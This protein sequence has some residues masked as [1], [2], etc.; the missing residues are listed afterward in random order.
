[1]KILTHPTCQDH[2]VPEGHPERPQRL[3]SLLDHLERTGFAQDHAI[4]HAPKA[5]TEDILRAHPSHYLSELEKLSP[6]EGINPVDPDT[7][8]SPDSYAAACIAA[9]AT[10]AGVDLL[11]SDQEKRVFCAV[12]PPGHHAERSGAMGFCL[13]NS[14]AIGALRALEH[15]DIHRVAILDFDV[16]HANG[17]VDI[18][19]DQ[20]EVLVCST[21]QHP[22][23]PNRLFDI[24]APNI[25]NSPLP[26]GSGS[27]EFRQAIEKDWMPALE[28]HQ[29]NLILVSAGFDAHAHDP[30]A[31]LNLFE[32]DYDWVTRII[33][34]AANQFAQGRVLSTLE[35]GYD[36]EALCNSVTAHLDALVVQG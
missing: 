24:A 1:M 29:P 7:W 4:L 30:L 11:L 8:M 2:Q 9:G 31:N 15:P 19:M 16:H 35:G 10:C 21:F 5:D 12:R 18:F 27:F 13:F 20:P 34:A 26:A 33:V 14:V 6:T 17:T 36:L 3:S 25:I 22:H 23:Y 28:R 32:D